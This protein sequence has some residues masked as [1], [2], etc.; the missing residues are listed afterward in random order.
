LYYFWI[1]DME[2]VILTEKRVRIRLTECWEAA[3][4]EEEEPLETSQELLVTRSS[5]YLQY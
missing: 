2:I 4:K 1:L 3:H 5:L